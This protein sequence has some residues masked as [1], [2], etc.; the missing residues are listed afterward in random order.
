VNTQKG[1]QQVI[2]TAAVY[3]H[4]WGH[5]GAPQHNNGHLAVK[6]AV[7]PLSCLSQIFSVAP[8]VCR[9]TLQVLPATMYVHD[10]QLRSLV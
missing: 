5:Q 4:S 3:G 1:V 8:A 6:M 9:L 10:E 7:K 2:A